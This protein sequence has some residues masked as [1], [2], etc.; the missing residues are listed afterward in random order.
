MGERD[1]TSHQPRFALGR[2]FL[3]FTM[4]V[5]DLADHRGC[6]G[7][8]QPRY[9]DTEYVATTMHVHHSLLCRR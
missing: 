2:T 5:A 4:T 8:E 9:L 3:Y 7:E 6:R 1:V